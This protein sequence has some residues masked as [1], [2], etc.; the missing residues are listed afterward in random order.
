MYNG[1][2]PSFSQISNGMK[3]DCDLSSA[4]G[5]TRNDEIM[6]FANS[7]IEDQDWEKLRHIIHRLYVKE[8]MKFED[9]QSLMILV[10]QFKA[11]R[12]QYY[13]HFKRW[14]EIRKNKTKNR[15]NATGVVLDKSS[16][17]CLRLNKKMKGSSPLSENLFM[18]LCCKS[19]EVP[20]IVSPDICLFQE[21]ILKSVQGIA[22][23]L[24]ESKDWRT[25]DSFTIIASDQTTGLSSVWQSLSD[26]AFGAARLARMSP[27]FLGQGVERL[28]SLFRDME[29]TM[30]SPDPSMLVKFWRI[31]RYIYD[32]CIV[33]NDFQTLS[34]FFWRY[35]EMAM[36]KLPRG[37]NPYPVARVCTALY[38]ILHKDPTALMDS[39]RIG[40]LK[41]IHSL[42]VF[43]GGDYAT[44]LA[45]WSN[46]LKHWDGNA[47]AQTQLMERYQHLLQA[48]DDCY[49]K[50]SESS[51]AI[52]DRFTYS[53]ISRTTSS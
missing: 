29:C 49:E 38:Q 20:R 6:T 37:T 34:S 10:Y 32:L 22:A 27:Q 8:K 11:T 18:W 13:A 46:Y 7:D 28:Q 31:C 26:R 47:L 14:P 45:M 39:L 16:S 41:S 53:P 21:T 40:Y 33:A 25:A 12:S 3:F 19:L 17:T 42:Q 4:M 44:V 43:V 9:F 50:T 23:G 24:F 1:A 5:R 36:A 2:E 30:K 52:L 51:L 48:S 15:E 35:G